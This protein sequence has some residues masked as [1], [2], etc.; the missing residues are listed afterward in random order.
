MARVL[1]YLLVALLAATGL[2]WPL[3]AGLD[4][5]DASAASDP[6]RIT[7]YTADYTVEADGGLT[8]TETVTVAFPAGRH[9]IFRY[10]D[11]TTGADPHVRHIPEIVSV[12]RDGAPEP[13]ET[14]RQQGHRF[15][16]AKIGDPDVYL[17]PG[18]HTY[19]IE[20]TTEGV[21]DPPGGAAATFDTAAGTAAP[22]GSVFHWS[23][24]PGGWEMAIDR[25]DITVRLPAASG[26]VECA[27][28]GAACILGGAGT[29]T[30]SVGV[31]G[32]EPRTAVNVR[33]G[34]GLD[35]PARATVP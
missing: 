33:I 12:E 23:V 5:G 15:V 19:R 2:L 9:G 25:A 34:L 17:E 29:D 24:V 14:S 10:W 28:S 8:A 6:A 27:V 20:Y 21:L 18:T 4:T 32:L 31:T 1:G 7:N 35:A 26:L 13:F 11:V 30:V 3:L 22:V 16:V